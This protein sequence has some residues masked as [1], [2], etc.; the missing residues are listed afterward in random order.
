MLCIA[1]VSAIATGVASASGPASSRTWVQ[2]FEQSTEGWYDNPPGT[3]E[4]VP[5][6]YVS[7]TAYG[8]LIASAH[9]RWHARL[10]DSGCGL[11]RF[12][13]N[14]NGP[15]TRWG[16]PTSANPV[17]P[18][19]GYMTEVDIYL[20]VDWVATAGGR[21]DY[22]YDW[23][24][25]I[26][27]NT[28]N[29]QRDFVF[30]VGTP[31][32]NAEALAA[33][34]YYVN[35]STNATRSGAFPQNPCPNP[36]TA[37]NYCRTPVKITQSGWYTFRHRFY[38]RSHMGVDYLAVDF[39]VLRH[40]GV[41]MANW[42]I[43]VTDT[44]DPVDSDRMSRI[45]GDRYGWFVMNEINDLAID[46]SNL[47]PPSFGHPPLRSRCEFHGDRRDHGREDND[48][49]DGDG[50]RNDRD[51][52]DDNDGQN[53]DVDQDD[54]NDGLFDEIDTDDDNDGIEDSFDSQ[55][56]TESQQGDFDEIGA[57]QELAYDLEAGANTLLLVAT[58]EVAGVLDALSPS[59]TV[60]IYNPAGLLVAASPPV[61][62]RVVAT[63]VP[64]L[65][66]TY[67]V[68]VRNTGSGP[69][70]YQASRLTRTLG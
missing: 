43:S 30:N 18:R 60:E 32:T 17:F 24:S 58:A 61:L 69:V 25:A 59:L 46:C 50:D 23:S 13:T 56:Q 48:D 38:S 28:G 34:G 33:P 11:I 36:F 57:G 42:F 47:R 16:K 39:T 45:G 52:D 63:A 1:L 7:P 35:A 20:D 26:N 9:G 15:F 54:D 37:P 40:D 67:K 4:R 3:I 21:N 29:H 10:R 19:G 55:S 65:P 44:Q 62:G 68:K 14:C 51:H 12:A 70:Q 5:S 64:V 27:D 22:R 53:D 66:G 49:H 2:D 6:G 41:V 31:L 8:N